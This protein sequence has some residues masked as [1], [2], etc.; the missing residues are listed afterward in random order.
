MKNLKIF[1]Y[2][3]ILILILWQIGK[4]LKF[5]YGDGI[6]NMIEFY[7]MPENSVDVLILGSSHAFENINPLVLWQNYGIASYILGG[8][9]Q[10]MWNTY[11]Y[12][13]EALKTQTPKLIILEAYTTTANYDFI[14][15]SRIIKNTYGMKW[16]RDRIEAIKVSAPQ[17]RWLEFLIPIFQEHILYAS[18]SP[19]DFPTLTKQKYTMN[20]WLGFGCN[21][22]LNSFAT[23]EI[24]LANKNNF[25]PLSEKTEK[26]FR[27]TIELAKEHN[28]PIVVVKS[29]YA[30]FNENDNSIYNSAE[31][32]ANEYGVKFINYN[33]QYERIGLDFSCDA[34]D[35]SHL[36]YNGNTKFSKILAQDIKQMFDIPDRRNDNLYTIWNAETQ[37][38]NE[39]LKA[40]GKQKKLPHHVI[41]S[42]SEH[43]H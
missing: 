5:H 11:F 43:S 16:S 31:K 3:T 30:G 27:K 25:L 2:I 4:P 26:Y 10:P 13:K 9:I 32:I 17:K 24:S 18:L 1:F 35:Y 23:P 20:M 28:I 14:D 40:N 41:S 29:P 15:D 37:R 8:S 34:A 6:Q 38:F 33:F 12:L 21:M 42:R 39:F 7:E 19:A 36:N 22:G